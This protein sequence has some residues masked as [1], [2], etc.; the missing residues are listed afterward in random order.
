MCSVTG[1]AST[2]GWVRI[3]EILLPAK[4]S[5]TGALDISIFRHT[6]VKTQTAQRSLQAAA[7]VLCQE[8]PLLLEGPPGDGHHRHTNAAFVHC[9]SP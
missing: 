2:N 3:N 6:F 5:I 9:Q 1:G 7:L 8:R 4:P